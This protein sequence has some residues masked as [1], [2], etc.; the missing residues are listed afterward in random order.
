[1]GDPAAAPPDRRGAG[2]VIRVAAILLEGD[3]IL[4]VRQ[5]LQD[6]RMWSLPGGRVEPGE[7]LEEAC[8]RELIEETGIRAEEARLL[9]VGER[10][11]RDPPLLH[12]AF[13]VRRS[14][15]ALRRPDNTHDDNP[16]SDV[17]FVALG[18]LARYGF[19]PRFCELAT[20]RFE[21]V[22]GSYVGAMASVGL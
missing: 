9:W 11:D 22:R 2:F 21:P 5:R 13:R 7:S 10:L 20:A 15:G 19:S 3:R 18:E 6:G 12:V 1:M 16:I 4:L 17:A 8:I 14:G